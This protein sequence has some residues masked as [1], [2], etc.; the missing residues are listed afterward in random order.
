MIYEVKKT[1]K[2]EQEG[3]EDKVYAF[4]IDDLVLFN[5]QPEKVKRFIDNN[6]EDGMVDL[7][8]S[9]IILLETGRVIIIRKEEQDEI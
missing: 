6:I 9:K 3:I 7:D 1:V 5:D 8:D 4:E 2:A